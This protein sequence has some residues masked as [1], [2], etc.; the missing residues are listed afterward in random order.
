[1]VRE[2]TTLNKYFDYFMYLGTLL[3]VTTFGYIYYLDKKKQINSRSKKRQTTVHRWSMCYYFLNILIFLPP[4]FFD[5]SSF[6]LLT[7][8]FLFSFLKPQLI[9]F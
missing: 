4:N 3:M 7:F 8:R 1:M 6:I 9:I 2:K 5:F